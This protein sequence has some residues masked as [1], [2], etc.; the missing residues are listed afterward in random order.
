[1]QN[2]GGSAEAFFYAPKTRLYTV[3]FFASLLQ[4]LVLLFI[5]LKL[6]NSSFE[7]M[8]APSSNSPSSSGSTSGS[9]AKTEEAAIFLPANHPANTPFAVETTTDENALSLTNG[10]S[11]V[12]SRALG[13][14]L[15]SG[16]YGATSAYLQGATMTLPFYTYGT[17]AMIASTTFFSGAYLTRYI[18]GNK[19]DDPS[20]YAISGMVNGFV[21]VSIFS[22]VKKGGLA[23]IVGGGLGAI[24]AVGSQWLYAQSREAWIQHRI[25]HIYFSKERKLIVSKPTFPTPQQREEVMLKRKLA[26]KAREEEAEGKNKKTGAIALEAAAVANTSSNSPDSNKK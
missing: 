24:Y 15:A 16:L 25:Q 26:A 6:M 22:G 18:R 10:I 14:T 7:R 17:S 21:S 12:S 20:N 4:H 9:S 23:G 8:S 3:V 13:W 11:F 19:E 5:Y 2:A 1:M